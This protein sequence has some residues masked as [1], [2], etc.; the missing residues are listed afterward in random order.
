M[1]KKMT[2]ES[3][4]PATGSSASAWKSWGAHASPDLVEKFNGECLD[5]MKEV[6]RTYPADCGPNHPQYGDLKR[7]CTNGLNRLA[8]RIQGE[9]D[10]SFDQ[11]E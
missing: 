9:E 2:P 4:D 6:R 11:D 3:V 7:D 5:V 10:E 8:E 1:S